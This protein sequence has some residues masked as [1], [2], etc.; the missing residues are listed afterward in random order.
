MSAKIRQSFLTSIF[1]SASLAA[2]VPLFFLFGNSRL[3]KAQLCRA[4][5]GCEVKDLRLTLPDSRELFEIHPFP[6]ACSCIKGL[7]GCFLATERREAEAGRISRLT[8]SSPRTSRL[9][10]L[11]FR[12][13]RPSSELPREEQE[14]GSPTVSDRVRGRSA[15]G[16]P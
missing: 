7:T 2:L 8:T 13:Q 15:F 9:C 1:V 3:T 10:C 6:L 11:L 4:L 12:I 14:A 16:K 5:N